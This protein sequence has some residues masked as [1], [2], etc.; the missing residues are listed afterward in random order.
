MYATKGKGYEIA[1]NNQTKWH[2]PGIFDKDTGIISKSK[3]LNEPISIKMFL[4]TIIELAR[5]IKIV[6]ITPA[7]PSGSS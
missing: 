5:K 7:M 1:E 4:E 6:G 3:N 2:A